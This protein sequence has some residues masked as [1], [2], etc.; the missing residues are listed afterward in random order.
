MSS[1]AWRVLVD[2]APWI[3]RTPIAASGR[4]P[5]ARSEVAVGR[6]L[7]ASLRVPRWRLVVVEETD[8]TASPELP[9]RPVDPEWTWSAGFAS[10]VGDVLSSTH[11]LGSG[12]T[13]WGPL[14]DR[15]DRLVGAAASNVAGVVD[16]W[17]LA[18]MWPFDGASLEAHPVATVA[19]GLV[20]C[21][22]SLEGAVLDAASGD[23]SLV[24][25]DLH[26]QHLLVRGGELAGVLDFGDAFIGSAAWDIALLRHY[27]GVVN[28]HAVALALDEG[29]TL[30]AAS[31]YLLVAVCAYKLAKEPARPG[32][33]DRLER[34][35][36][37][38]VP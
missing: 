35:L 11:G 34:A 31:R 12:A 2:D 20:D 24:H 13:G 30:L 38:L 4:R 28:A 33:V 29:E 14:V 36:D 37:G 27:Y 3:I 21:L 9:G 8:C 17:F 5:S 18:R 15:D 26:A 19:P 25:S 22:A 32:I 23:R 6:L 10:A 7:P 1:T 16:R